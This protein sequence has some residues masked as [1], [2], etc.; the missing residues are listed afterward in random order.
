VR[1]HQC[2]D[3][4]LDDAQLVKVVCSKHLARS[5]FAL[6][7]QPLRLVER[8][9]LAQALVLVL[10]QA[11]RQVLVL[12]LVLVLVPVPAPAPVPVP[13]QVE[14][15]VLARALAKQAQQP[16]SPHQQLQSQCRPELCRLH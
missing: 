9:A 4:Q 13:V 7:L 15:Q 8:P 11:E 16:H 2:R 6:Q 3:R 10:V 5:P 12:V 1:L 14:Q